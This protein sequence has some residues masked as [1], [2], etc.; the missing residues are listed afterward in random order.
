[1]TI[2]VFAGLASFDYSDSAAAVDSSTFAVQN[3]LGYT[4]N[5]MTLR[6]RWRWR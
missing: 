5:N 1:V 4:L 2:L 6:W 3:L